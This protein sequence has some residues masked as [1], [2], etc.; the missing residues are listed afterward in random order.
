MTNY[1][2]IFKLAIGALWTAGHKPDQAAKFALQ[3]A[4][5]TNI[6]MEDLWATGGHKQAITALRECGYELADDLDLPRGSYDLVK[7]LPMNHATI[8][9][10]G[11]VARL[12][13]KGWF[14]MS[15]GQYVGL[16]GNLSERRRGFEIA[17]AK[18][19]WHRYGN[20]IS[21]GC[22]GPASIGYLDCRNLRPTGETYRLHA[23]EWIGRPQANGG[24]YFYLT[25]PVW[26]WTPTS[27][28]VDFINADEAETLIP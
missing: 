15:E 17:N 9:M 21:M 23:W 13:G 5:G 24:A 25:V 7:P 2:P 19:G 26:E 4:C 3:R 16:Q 6:D 22:G 1:S 8:P 27:D 12:T 10:A 18:G 20:Y 14:T 11:H 28:S